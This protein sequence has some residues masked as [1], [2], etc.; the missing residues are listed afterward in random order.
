MDEKRGQYNG[1]YYT[2]KNRKVL[3]QEVDYK[4]FGNL[5]KGYTVLPGWYCPY[6]RIPFS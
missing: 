3:G 5:R 6:R 4:A 1:V 2:Q